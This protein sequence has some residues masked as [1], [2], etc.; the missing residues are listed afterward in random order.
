MLKDVPYVLSYEHIGPNGQTSSNSY[1]GYTW[2]QRSKKTYED[3]K[4]EDVV[5]PQFHTLRNK[6]R[7]VN[8]DYRKT[9]VFEKQSL[10]TFY[11]DTRKYNNGVYY[12]GYERT[13]SNFGGEVMCLNANSYL[14]PSS[15]INVDYLIDKVVTQLHA[16]IS[17][18]PMKGLVTLGELRQT[19]GLV[20]S[21]GQR[22]NR[23]GRFLK[24][25]ASHPEFRKASISGVAKALSKGN[26]IKTANKSVRRLAQQWLEYRYGIRQFYFDYQSSMKAIRSLNVPQRTRYSASETMSQT[27][28]DTTSGPLWAPFETSYL[29][30]FVSRRVTVDAG[31]LVEPKVVMGP[32]QAY[33][34]DEVF[35]AA[36][37]LTRFSFVVDW[38]VN[39]GTKVAA[40]SP[41]GD[42]NILA[43]WVVV[44][45]QINQYTEHRYTIKDN[46]VQGTL[47]ETY[48][49]SL[50][51]CWCEKTST[52]TTR[53]R[54]P[55]VNPIPNWDIN[56]NVGKI[57]DLVSIVRTLPVLR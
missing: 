10:G 39:V 5:T 24:R 21:L 56:L 42:V 41:K 36:W 19:M 27:D 52:T 8:N 54:D 20:N 16:R 30:R 17:S 38:F 7:I 51:Q 37:D 46:V 35:Q 26:R 55:A 40:L 32:L 33:G 29:D 12:D 53:L 25:A 18:A 28:E 9:D 13:Y 6:G 23:A 43:T 49:C 15:T 11:I 34:M 48:D 45:D 3:E 31:A 1:E 50:D 44:T 14:S 2:G 47:R 22:I 57:A 4:I